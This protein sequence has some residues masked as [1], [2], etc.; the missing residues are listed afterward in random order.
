[1][2][3]A[4]PD[5]IAASNAGSK[6]GTH[7][8]SPTAAICTDIQ[9][10]K[11]LA[12]ETRLCILMS[13]RSAELTVSELVRIL[14]LHQSSISRHLT[15]IRNAG[16]LLDRKEGTLVYYRW[17][18][19][20]RATP[21]LRNLLAEVWEPWPERPKLEAMLREVL[22]ERRKR[23]QDFFDRMAGRYRRVAET[24][25]SLDALLR[26]FSL[27]PRFGT[28]VDIGCG[29]GDLAL[30]LARCC[31]Q[32]IAVD[33]SPRMLEVLRERCAEGG[34]ANIETRNG[35]IEALPLKDSTVDLVVLS[36]VL[37][38]GAEPRKALEELARVLRP[39][40]RFLLLDLDAHDQ[41][42]A[43]EKLGD[44]WLGFPEEQVRRWLDELG[45]TI[46]TLE[47]IPVLDGLPVLL[48]T[49]SRPQ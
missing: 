8:G 17:S 15:Q 47:H 38:H 16:L 26:A 40:G 27:L 2:P 39:G 44:L 45:L 18:E 6:V 5:S 48:C 24:G 22:E 23:S 7:A 21:S 13:L 28:A 20:L 34:I 30:L 12:D 4:H 42:W 29:E 37:H 36:Q 11:V 43:R 31:G 33:R 19:A 41:E 46:E 32:V 35:D 10:L 14:G 1:M 49:G 25:G 3:A 9:L